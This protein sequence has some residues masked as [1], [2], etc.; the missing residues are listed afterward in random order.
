MTEMS[1]G[2]DIDLDKVDFAFDELA[3]QQLHDVLRGYRERGPVQPTHFMGRPAFVIAGH[4]ALARAFLDEQAFPGHRMYVASFEPAVGPSFISNPDPKE[5]LAYRKLA[6]PAFRSRAISSYERTGLAALAH[7]LIDGLTDHT[8]FDLVESFTARF[9]Y[10]V[11]TRL[12]GLPRDREDEFHDWAIALLSFRDNPERTKQA[13]E[14]FSDFLAPAVAERRRNP[15]N[16][17]ISELIQA[18][19][20]GRQLTDEE[21]YSHVRLL[22]PAGGETTYGSLGNLLY[23]LLTVDDAWKRI[24]HEPERIDAAVAEA[25]RWET[26]IAVLPRLSSTEDTKFEGISIPADS[27][28]LFAPAGA[29]RDPTFFRDPDRF[30]IDRIQPP[31]LTFGRGLKSCPGMHLAKKSMSVA[32]QVLAERLPGLRLVD[33][34]AAIPVRSVLRSPTALRVECR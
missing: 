5:H 33:E 32:V 6:T 13:R 27:W 28:V 19:I 30:D 2:P 25:L 23:A 8:S 21:I 24:C 22:F 31:N 4:D 16:D 17:V 9:P 15:R 3:G 1:P 34:N 11:I 29:N 7:E 26:P 18:E 20:D 14:A 12:L 10:L